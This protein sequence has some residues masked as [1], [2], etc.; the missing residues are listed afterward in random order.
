MTEIRAMAEVN[1]VEAQHP[2]V[3]KRVRLAMSYALEVAAQRGVVLSLE[4]AFQMQQAK[5]WTGRGC[6]RCS[7]PT[8]SS[9]AAPASTAGAS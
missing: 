9:R 6:A 8:S 5:F 2:R 7:R 3:F 1:R 4:E